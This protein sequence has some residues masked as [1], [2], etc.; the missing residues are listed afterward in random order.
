MSSSDWEIVENSSDDTDW[1]TVD[2]P[3]NQPVSQYQESKVPFPFAL[4]KNNLNKSLIEMMPEL[5]DPKEVGKALLQSGG[6]LAS[7]AQPEVALLA[8][9]LPHAPKI[10]NAL[11][12]MGAQAG[13]GA[14]QAPENP[15][16]GAGM[17]AGGSG[18][19]QLSGIKNPMLNALLRTLVGGGMGVGAGK[20]TGMN[21]WETGALG[22]SIGLGA[23][24]IAKTLGFSKSKPGLETLEHLNRG[25]IQEPVNAA[26][27][28]NTPI[29]PAEASGN[30]FVGGIEGTFGR[31]GE[32][33]ALKTKIAQERIGKQQSAIYDLL[34]TIYDKST[35]EAAKIS[36]KKI[37]DL[38]QQAFK[39]NLKPEIMA[40]IKN[41]HVIAAAFERVKADPAYQRKLNGIPENNYSYLNQ[42]KRSLSDM[43]GAAIKKGENDR[44]LEFNEARKNLVDMMD[45]G[46]PAYA[47]A[48][49]EA[50]KS[51]VRSNIQKAMRK[52]ELKGSSFYNT[53]LKNDDEFNKLYDSL[54]NVPEAQDKLND[55]KTAW[56]HLIDI[57]KPKNAAFRAETGLGQ[58]RNIVSKLVDI[59]NEMTGAKRNIEALRFIHSPKWDKSFSEILEIKNEKQ[60]KDALADFITTTVI[61]GNIAI[62]SK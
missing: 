26:N 12:R 15:L 17:G 42:V 21:P 14:A 55:M 11:M 54:K 56:K 60:R 30:P 7:F 51:I 62:N 39:W 57:E 37:E 33:A 29:T 13:Y 50:Q 49:E 46:V 52:K 10:I 20:V 31:T 47:K 5:R 40:D 18:L 4:D 38:Y 24:K 36:R 41:D 1:Q 48:R 59:W 32:A 8:K 28:L 34:D 25:D 53:L 23:P 44:A 58:S 6:I 45:E 3:I 61:G 27:R 9:A 35:P 16:L 43:E 19:G 22:A 2:S